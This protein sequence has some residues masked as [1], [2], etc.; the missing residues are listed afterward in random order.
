MSLFVA[1]VGWSGAIIVLASYVLLSTRRLDG[2]SITYHVMNLLGAIGVGV[3]SAWNGA[4]PST[5]VNAIWM[6]I[7]IYALTR[8]RNIEPESGAH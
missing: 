2:N 7:A 5:A 1:V 6:G 4:V 3:N 8:H